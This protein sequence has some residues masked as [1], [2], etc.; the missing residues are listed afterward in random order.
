MQCKSCNVEMS[1]AAAGASIFA[2]SFLP[3]AGRKVDRA[4]AI[5]IAQKVGPL[6]RRCLKDCKELPASDEDR[7]ECRSLDPSSAEPTCASREAPESPHL[8]NRGAR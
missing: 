3:V 2:L 5:A 4:R 8:A 7:A 1:E 6:C